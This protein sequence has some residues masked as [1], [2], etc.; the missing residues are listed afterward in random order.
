[1]DQDQFRELK[2]SGGL[3]TDAALQ[4]EPNEPV[5]EEEDDLQDTPTDEHEDAQDDDEEDEL[6]ALSEKEKTAFEKRMERERT[7]LQEKLEAELQQKYEQQ[8]GRH[9]Q[10]IEM[11]GGD[12]DAIE[13]RIRDNQMAQEAQRLAEVNGWDDEQTQWYVEQ[14]KQQQELKELRVQMQINRLKDNPDYAGI[15]SMEKDI[16]AKID[17]SN[18]ALSVDEAYWALGGP[19]RAE[20]I[21]LEAQVRES[22]KRAQK[23]RTVL[24]DSPTSNTGEKPLPTE[25]MREAERMGISAAEARRLMSKEPAKDLADWRAQKQKQKK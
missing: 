25:V 7:K 16:L 12:P 22:T 4:E 8:Y 14:Q 1:M 3:A 17:R 15:A 19:K 10:V 11:L 23:P 6:P 21:R 20:Q 5:V 24:T 2:E 13:K 18:G 9:K